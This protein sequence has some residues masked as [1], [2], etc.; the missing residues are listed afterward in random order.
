MPTPPFD[1]EEPTNAAHRPGVVRRLH[2]APKLQDD[3][4]ETLGLVMGGLASLKTDVQTLGSEVAAL[5]RDIELDRRALVHGASTKAA[6]HTSN[7]MA[8]LMGALFTV[9]E[10]AAPY[11]PGI[12]GMFHK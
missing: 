6:A 7:R 10:I 1:D 4:V 9:Y 8:A 11:W 5:R 2:S 3:E 12:R